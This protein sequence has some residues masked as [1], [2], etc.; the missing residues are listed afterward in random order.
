MVTQIDTDD[1]L[2]GGLIEIDTL[3][4]PGGLVADYETSLGCPGLW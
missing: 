2:G 1:V 3:V 4:L